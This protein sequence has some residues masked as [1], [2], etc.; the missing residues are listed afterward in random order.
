M[1]GT[2]AAARPD[3]DVRERG[4][5]LIELVVAMVILAVVSLAVIAVILQAQ[6][7]GVANRSRIAASNLADREIEMVRQ[8][9]TA[10]DAGPLAVAN[11]GTVVDA[12]PLQGGTA[13]QPLVVDGRPYT[14]TRS[15]Q[16]N[17]TGSGASACEG[18]AAV[19][20]P[21]LTVTVKVTWEDM[22][23][24]RPV[25]VSTRLAP[26]K[27]LGLSDKTAYI[28]AKVRDQD[29]KPLA[30][31]AVSATGSGTVTGKTDDTGCVVLPVTPA[32]STGT[33]YTVQIADSSYIDI[34]GTTNPSKSTG[35]IKQGTLYS[36]ASFSIAKPGKAI[37]TLVRDDGTPLTDA[38]VAGSKVTLVASEY[39]GA[40]GAVTKTVSTVKTTFTN[41]WPTTY[42]AYFGTVPP[43]AGYTVQELLADGAITLD[44]PFTMA[45]VPVQNLP[46]GTTTVYAVPTGTA[47]TATSC[48][49]SGTQTA[50]ASGTTATFDAMPGEY[51][52]YFSGA[53]FKCASGPVDVPFASGTNDPVVL[54]NTTISIS[55]APGGTVW[56]LNQAK[57]GITSSPTTCPSGYGTLAVNI[58]TA[59][60][61]T[62]KLPAGVWYFWQGSADGSTCT[63]YPNVSSPT[64]IIYGQNNPVAWSA[65]TTL[66]LTGMTKNYYFFVI[67]GT[68]GSPTCL[69]SSITP[70]AGSSYWISSSATTTTP[71]SLSLTIPR[72]STTKTYKAFQ[73]LS[74][75]TTSNSCVSVGSFSVGPSTA[76]ASMVGK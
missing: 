66:T 17:A 76:S 75:A 49:P 35:I 1:R 69:K 63:A 40:T 51:D 23:Q 54:A 47:V 16:W 65:T 4:F 29:D 43:L 61:G 13:G 50:S 46:D 3:T 36:G 41:L 26:E 22:G 70:P 10:T 34:S 73:S 53:T 48:A 58:D 24:A 25:T 32:A 5:T 18:G 59:R 7:A 71:Q 60:S 9:F 20:Y 38:Q 19:V 8:Q 42:G 28:A 37:V 62:A 64:T 14:V 2:L 11:A 21:A 44:V 15:A 67:D 52:L 45:S 30:N 68:S 33:T 31:V 56:A 27:D 55:G 12:Y 57:A 6:G 72:P 39:S 74:T